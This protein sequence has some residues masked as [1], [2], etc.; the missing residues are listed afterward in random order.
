MKQAMILAAG[1]GTR[2]KPLT[3]TMPKA[4]V[5]VG[6]RPLLDITLQRLMNAGYDRFVVNVHHFGQQ[7][8]DH[9]AR[10]E[11][12]SRLVRISD[13]RE[14]LLDTGG[15][16]KKA[17]DLFDGSEPILIHNVDILDNVDYHWFAQ[18]H[19]P[20]ED[21]ALLVSRRKTKRYLLFDNAM[22]LM[23]WKN[24][25]TGEIR[26]PYE[27]VR[28]TGRSQY[29]EELNMFAFSGI[30]SFSPR[31]FPLMQRFPDRFGIIDFYLSV[32]HRARIYGCIKDDL[33][34]LDV[35]KL[36]SLAEASRFKC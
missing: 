27:Y 19:L 12:Y 30:H 11:T 24:V 23:G 7:I 20:D 28:R 5:P 25:E 6:G 26:S 29:G 36:D 8:I 3:D 22:R 35:G 13:E 14:Q 2:L 32:C 34:V 1:L 10:N 31:L 21:A 4:L 16:L 9:I 17:A 15:G 33:Q 18:Q